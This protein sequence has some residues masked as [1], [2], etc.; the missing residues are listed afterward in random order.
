MMVEL[1]KA[2]IFLCALLFFSTTLLGEDN[3][4]NFAEVDDLVAFAV[5]EISKPESERNTETAIESF[6]AAANK[7]SPI[8]I[9]SLG[10]IYLEGIGVAKDKEKAFSYF[11]EGAKSL[12]PP[13]QN[14]LANLYMDG[15]PDPART[16]F[17]YKK[18][19]KLYENAAMSGHKYAQFNIGDAYRTGKGKP[20]NLVEAHTWFEKAAEQGVQEA[21]YFLGVSY[22]SGAAGTKNQ[23]AAFHWFC[24]AA[25]EN[26]KI[27][28]ILESR[29]SGDESCEDAIASGTRSEGSSFIVQRLNERQKESASLRTSGE[30]TAVAPGGLIAT[31]K[32]EESQLQ[33]SFGKFFNFLGEFTVEVV[34]AAI[35]G[36]IV[37]KIAEELDLDPAIFDGPENHKSMS[38]MDQERPIEFKNFRYDA[39]RDYSDNTGAANSTKRCSCECVNGKMAALCPTSVDVAPICVG[40]CPPFIPAP[41]P[42]PILPSILP[43]TTLCRQEKV[44][45]PAQRSY[46]WRQICR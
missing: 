15:Y 7:G 40:S 44:Y 43:G 4:F 18:A 29:Y 17:N 26:L 32:Y 19:T 33:K 39:V 37:Y 11:S 12:F 27:T 25:K 5:L 46:E 1:K 42:Y 14:S 30:R 10:L 6:E 2:S 9:H 24:R 36:A 45:S 22:E 34:S 31:Q 23:P 41:N 38:R 8:A 13:S 21:M 3:P 28:Q 16:F 35:A 20:K